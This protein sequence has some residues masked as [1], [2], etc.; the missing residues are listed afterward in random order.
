M[1]Y[2][3][4]AIIF[5]AFTVFATVEYRF[6]SSYLIITGLESYDQV[7][8]HIDGSTLNLPGNSLRIPWEKGKNAEIKLI[9][10]RNNDKLQP[11]FLKINASKDNP[12]VFRTRIPSYLPAGKIQVEYL[13]YDDWDTPEKI[14]KRA[15]IDGNPVDIFREG[16]IELDTFFL[17]S[18]E[19]RLRIVLKDSSG[20]VTDQTYRFTVVP[21]LPSPPLVKDGKILSS[22]LHRIYTIQGGEIINKEVSGEIDLKESICF[23][24][25][26]D[27]AGNESAPV[28]FY[29]YP[30]LQ[31]LENASLISLTS[32]ELK[33]KDYTVLGRV[34]IANRDTVVLKSGASLRIAPGSS[35]IVRG[36]FIAEPGSRIYGQGQLI[37]GDDA[38]VILN[39][40][41]VEADVLI[42]GSN[43]VWIANSKI[44]SR[45]SVSRSLLLAF[46][47]VSLKELFASNVRRLWF[48]SVSIQ[49]LS[50]SN[51]SYF[52]MVDSTISERIQIE[53]FSNGRIYNSKFY[54]NDLPIFVSN[55]S[56]IEMID[57]W[58]SAKRCVLVQDFSVFRARST[59]FNGDN[60]IFVSGFSIFDGFAISVTSATAITLRDSRARLVQSEI[61]GKTV[62][63]GRSEILKP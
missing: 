49:N 5:I 18:G 19:R 44:N 63:L 50:L 7:E 22:R 31:V 52:L 41:K 45:I 47:N 57:C 21:H 32:G 39:G 29:S 43:M 61:N 16:Y 37:I 24:T 2:F 48:N 56:R 59:Q 60:A 15:F 58:V 9:P 11:I 4:L 54:S 26:V 55:F 51:I 28:L 17:R 33:D 8:L 23:I 1:R 10:I 3:A 42:N 13:I 40:A 53:D 27:G 46:Q 25:D 14:T 30:N 6:E 62:S 34:M 12:P 20:K 35:I 38:K 36:S